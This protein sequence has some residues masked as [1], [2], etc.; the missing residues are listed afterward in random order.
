MGPAARATF[1]RKQILEALN[2]GNFYLT[3][4]YNGYKVVWLGRRWTPYMEVKAGEQ[5]LIT[6]VSVYVPGTIQDVRLTVEA[7]R[8]ISRD[9]YH[10]MAEALA[11]L[12][13]KR[14]PQS[15]R[16]K[17]RMLKPEELM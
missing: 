5:V 17:Y 13:E 12:F 9:L 16:P 4:P 15:R 1:A 14:S 10:Y 8:V 7:L 2:R 11:G 6:P 3:A